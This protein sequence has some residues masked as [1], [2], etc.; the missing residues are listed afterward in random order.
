MRYMTLTMARNF[1]FVSA[2]KRKA[3]WICVWDDSPFSCRDRI[4]TVNDYFIALRREG[5]YSLDFEMTLID[6]ASN[7]VFSKNAGQEIQ[8]GKPHVFMLDIERQYG[9]TAPGH[10]HRTNRGR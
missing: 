1:P 9:E 5:W 7:R 4:A 10:Q 3:K 2:P 6:S 8:E